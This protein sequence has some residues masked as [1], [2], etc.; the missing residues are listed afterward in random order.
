ME[1]LSRIHNFGYI[2]TS[3]LLHE[4]ASALNGIDSF[5]MDK[6]LPFTDSLGRYWD[7]YRLYLIHLSEDVIVRLG[8]REMFAGYAL[9]K[10]NRFVAEGYKNIAVETLGGVE[11]DL[12]FNWICKF[13]GNSLNIQNVNVV[14]EGVTFSED[15]RIYIP[16]AYSIEN[17]SSLEDLYLRV[18]EMCDVLVR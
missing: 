2:S 7:N 10:F 14:R 4:M 15:S 5:S 13:Y 9:G 3:R 1:H 11:Y 8:G 17:K 18:D 12:I 16:D 6:S